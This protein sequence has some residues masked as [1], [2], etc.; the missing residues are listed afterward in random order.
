[1]YKRKM[2]NT[3]LTRSETSA[4][5]ADMTDS[6]T[7]ASVADSSTISPALPFDGFASE[8]VDV[9]G[10]EVATLWTVVD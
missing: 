2:E 9:A 1:M 10:D 4:M 3:H 6:G 8:V 5:N 7:S